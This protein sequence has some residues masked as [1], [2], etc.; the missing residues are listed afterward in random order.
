MPE[1]SQL[2]KCIDYEDKKLIL[3]IVDEAINRE[4]EELRKIATRK[5]QAMLKPAFVESFVGIRSSL[6]R[7]HEEFKR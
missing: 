5:M 4:N 3:K 6:M 7:V 1:T 2:N